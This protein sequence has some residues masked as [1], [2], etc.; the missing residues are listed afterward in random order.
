MGQGLINIF[1]PVIKVLNV[2]ISKLQVFAAYFSAITGAL[3]GKAQ[4]GATN[5]SNSLGATPKGLST[6]LGNVGASSS[7]ASKGLN[8][9]SKATKKVGASAKKAKK[10]I[11]GLIGG[12]D[13]IN[14]L[15]SNKTDG[16]NNLPSSGT[17]S[18]PSSGGIGDLGIGDI[19]T[20]DMA[21]TIDTSRLD[22][23]T[24]KIAAIF[25]KIKNIISKNK[26]AI[27]AIMAGLT[28]GIGF[29]MIKNWGKITKVLSKT[30]L[31][32]LRFFEGW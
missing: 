27:I 17:S 13:E 2:V 4:E 19:G 14:N 21:S 31:Y 22:A 23:K 28:A 11:K 6:S 24:E 20:I 3:F 12:L 1:L 10:E 29:L 8:K 26:D 18:T 9:A 25:S 5:V 30:F 32:Y 7:N 15:T 16:T